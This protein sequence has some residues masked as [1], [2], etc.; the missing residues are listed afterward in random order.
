MESMQVLIESIILTIP[1][2]GL[3]SALLLLLW[4]ITSTIGRSLFGETEGSHFSSLSES[5]LANV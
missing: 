3:L 5:L 4:F 2:W 1:S